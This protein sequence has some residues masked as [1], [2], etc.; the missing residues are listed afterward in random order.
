MG[1]ADSDSEPQPSSLSRAP[2]LDLPPVLRSPG[3]CSESLCSS[4]RGRIASARPEPHG[5]TRITIRLDD[6]L[7]DYFLKEA[8][9]S[10][11][12][13]GCQT[14]MNDAL[15]QFIERQGAEV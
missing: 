15:R 14:L 4:R 11:G 3:T 8:N 2:L 12:K 10:G 9:G 13:V 6:E 1:S 5:K 7:V